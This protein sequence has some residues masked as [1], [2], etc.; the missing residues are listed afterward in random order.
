MDE[1]KIEAVNTFG[2]VLHTWTRATLFAAKGL[3]MTAV[4]MG[5]RKVM[6]RNIFGGHSSD[7]LFTAERA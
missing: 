4:N 6:V 5:Y 3:A 2:D 1:F 7:V